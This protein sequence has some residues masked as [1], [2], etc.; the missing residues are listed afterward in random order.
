MTKEKVI[1]LK[2]G[3]VIKESD[4]QF[5]KKMFIRVCFKHAHGKHR[6]MR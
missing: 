2:C 6:E 4:K 5:R 1:R 3:C